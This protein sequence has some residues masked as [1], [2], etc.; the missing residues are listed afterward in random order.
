ME[1]AYLHR[2]VVLVTTECRAHLAAAF[3]DIQSG[4]GHEHGNVTA[5]NS[6]IH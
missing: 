3:F 2:A 6:S 1:T 5:C 4:C